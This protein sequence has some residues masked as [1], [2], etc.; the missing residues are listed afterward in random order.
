[1]KTK[2]EIWQNIYKKVSHLENYCKIE[3]NGIDEET[4]YFHPTFIV[5]ETFR[6]TSQCDLGNNHVYALNA[7]FS[8]E[9]YFSVSIDESLLDSVIIGYHTNKETVMF[10]LDT[11]VKVR[12]HINNLN[13][14]TSDYINSIL[15]GNSINEVTNSFVNELHSTNKIISFMQNKNK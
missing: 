8:G 5:D 4:P 13:Y 15:L 3:V 10:A 14:Y 6:I 9:N 12:N 1:M 7:V 2:Q 11:L